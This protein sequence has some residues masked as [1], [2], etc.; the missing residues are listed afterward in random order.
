MYE[1]EKFD[2]FKEKGLIYFITFTQIYV[3]AL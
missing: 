2:R 1:S 3:A